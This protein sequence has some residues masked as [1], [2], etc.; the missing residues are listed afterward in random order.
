[1][2]ENNDRVNYAR[3]VEQLK[4]FL[5]RYSNG[6]RAVF[7]EVRTQIDVLIEQNTQPDI[8]VIW[9]AT[10]KGP[11]A[12]PLNVHDLSV[13]TLRWEDKD[14]DKLVVNWANE[15]TDH[16]VFSTREAALQASKKLINDTATKKLSEAQA[17]ARKA[18]EE[19][20]R[21][22]ID[23]IAYANSLT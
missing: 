13:Y 15:E 3:V 11:V 8:D 2:N 4:S 6:T 17:Q 16:I 1:M 7:N 9:Y 21:F 18:I 5:N 20:Q 23:Q 10:L 14:A 22:A 19:A 12:Y